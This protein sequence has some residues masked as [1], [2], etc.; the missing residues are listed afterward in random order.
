MI[1]FNFKD[2]HFLS[3]QGS[4]AT[5]PCLRPKPVP[6]LRTP[7]VKVLSTIVGFMS[8]F[9]K[10]SKYHHILETSNYNLS[11]IRNLKRKF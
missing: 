8:I 7:M 9:M 2:F 1:Y 10:K 11:A 3:K 4:Y 5:V 6:C